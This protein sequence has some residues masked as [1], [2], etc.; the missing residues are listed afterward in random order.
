[1]E[2]AKNQF[3]DRSRSGIWL[4]TVSFFVTIH[5]SGIT[6]APDGGKCE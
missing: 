6:T 3:L 1:M 4:V 2:Y 5:G